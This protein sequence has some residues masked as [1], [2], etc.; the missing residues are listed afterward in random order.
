M[1]RSPRAVQTPGE[2]PAG[3]ATF[4]YTV[5][6]ASGATGTGRAPKS[7]AALACCTSPWLICVPSTLRHSRMKAARPVQPLAE[8]MVP[9]T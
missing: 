4:D 5:R 8:T 6:D 9:S 7:Q 3:L 1:S 2:A